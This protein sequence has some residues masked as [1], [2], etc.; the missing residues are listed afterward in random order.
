MSLLLVTCDSHA[1][2]ACLL[3]RVTQFKRIS[4]LLGISRLVIGNRTND[5]HVQKAA[6]NILNMQLGIT[7]S[8]CPLFLVFAD[9][10]NLI[11]K[12]KKNSNVL[13][14][15]VQCVKIYGWWSRMVCTA[16]HGNETSSSVKSMEILDQSFSTYV[17]KWTLFRGVKSTMYLCTPRREEAE[18][19][20]HLFL[21]SAEGGASGRSVIR[22]G[23]LSPNAE[24]HW[25]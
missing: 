9:A 15:V 14:A 20:D 6:A 25:T 1:M 11:L 22:P 18:E 23:R 4:C 8:G 3:L 7:H 16:E 21:M 12:E 2:P 13:Q 19:F 24:I 5:L 10:E 17:L